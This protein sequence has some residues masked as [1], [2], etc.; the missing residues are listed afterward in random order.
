MA[1]S[2]RITGL[3]GTQS[4]DEKAGFITDGYLYKGDTPQGDAKFNV[5]PPG[6]EIDNQ[7]TARIYPMSLVKLT[8]ESYP[9]DGW[10]PKP[11][12]VVD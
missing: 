7:P 3:D 11:R 5:M 12:A 6:M 9:G 8:E 4:L 1:N 10:T 2:E